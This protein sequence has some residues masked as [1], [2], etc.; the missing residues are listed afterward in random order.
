MKSKTMNR[1]GTKRRIE[2]SNRRWFNRHSLIRLSILLSL[3]ALLCSAYIWRRGPLLTIREVPIRDRLIAHAGGAFEGMT[4][5]NSL[6]AM[7]HNYA[8]GFRYFE[9]DF[10]WTQDGELVCVHDWEATYAKLFH[11]SPASIPSLEEFERLEMKAG[12]TQL[13]LDSVMHWLS[14]KK[15]AFLV[16]DIKKDN[17]Q[18]LRLIKERY[19]VQIQQVVPQVYN[20]NEISPTRSLGFENVILTLY[21]CPLSR[22]ELLSR[23]ENEELFAVTVP[24]ARLKR[25]GFA[26]NLSRRFFVYTHTVNS[27]K[28]AVDSIEMG[29]DGFYTDSLRPDSI[30]FPLPSLER[31][32]QLTK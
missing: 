24:K 31:R 18:A 32:G 4:Y 28:E 22:R 13:S 12:L 19:V 6:Q 20:P 2:F 17:L 1:K 3:A 21:R 10:N 9:V 23:L 16:T 15:D 29:V 27:E 8:A 14:L 5:T 30:P 25:W 26:K 11:E 7:E